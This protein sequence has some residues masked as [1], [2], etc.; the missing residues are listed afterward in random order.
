MHSGS[1]FF[2]ANFPFLSLEARTWSNNFFF[3]FLTEDGE[4]KEKEPIAN[5]FFPNR[6][7]KNFNLSSIGEGRLELPFRRIKKHGRNNIPWV[8]L[9]PIVTNGLIRLEQR[10]LI[11][12]W[13]LILVSVKIEINRS[14]ARARFIFSHH[15]SRTSSLPLSSPAL[16]IV[17]RNKG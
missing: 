10:A 14:A 2:R 1:P 4:G 9:P 12:A 15:E 3:L 7:G 5:S 13:F 17:L 6:V 8:P 11:A 16:F